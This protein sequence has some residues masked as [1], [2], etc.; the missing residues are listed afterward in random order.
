MVWLHGV[1]DVWCS[2][3]H[4]QQL[5]SPTMHTHTSAWLNLWLLNGRIMCVYCNQKAGYPNGHTYV[6]YIGLQ[7]III[8]HLLFA[9]LHG[10]SALIWFF[11]RWWWY[12]ETCLMRGTLPP[13]RNASLKPTWFE[14]FFKDAFLRLTWRV[15]ILAIC[16]FGHGN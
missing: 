7:Q 10:D 11:L 6:I 14:I 5:A 8:C 1:L 12:A 15:Q 2:W 3:E 4:V 9:S 16:F 13:V